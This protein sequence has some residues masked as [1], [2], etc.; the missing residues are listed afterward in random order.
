MKTKLLLI[1]SAFLS[2]GLFAQTVYIDDQQQL[3][4][5]RSGP[6][7]EFRLIYKLAPGTRL[8]VLES[9]DE[10]G[11]FRVKNEQDKIFWIEQKYVT[12]EPTNNYRLAD[13]ERKI[14]TLTAQYEEKVSNLEKQLEEL[15]PLKG[16]NQE[17]L[18]KLTRQEVE[19]NQAVE[20]AQIYESGFQSDAFRNGGLVALGGIFLGWLF[21]RVGGK[22]RNSGWN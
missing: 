19:L 17:L 20:K 21:G 11:Y 9:N 16:G 8:E 3:V 22:K 10:A 5:T 1:F 15:A 12:R 18:A 7:E 6:G 14:K 2:S 13:A 4:W